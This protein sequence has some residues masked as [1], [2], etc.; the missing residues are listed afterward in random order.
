MLG[1]RTSRGRALRRL[2]RGRKIRAGSVDRLVMME[3]LLENR[4]VYVR[5]CHGSGHGGKEKVTLIRDRGDGWTK[6]D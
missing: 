2:W 5:R 6:K 4:R 1:F 3:M